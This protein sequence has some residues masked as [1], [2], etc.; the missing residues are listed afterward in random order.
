MSKGSLTRQDQANL[1][2]FLTQVIENH[3]SGGMSIADCVSYIKHVV[4]AVDRG[5][6][7]EVRRWIEEGRPAFERGLSEQAKSDD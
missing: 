4:N 5:D 2:A 6:I 7:H 3:T 1:T